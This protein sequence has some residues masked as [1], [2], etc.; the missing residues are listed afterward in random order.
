MRND[1]VLVDGCAVP[2][3]EYGERVKQPNE[4]DLPDQFRFSCS[5]MAASMALPGAPVHAVPVTLPAPFDCPMLLVRTGMHFMRRCLGTARR[6]RL[7][8]GRLA[9]RLHPARSS[10]LGLQRL[11]SEFRRR[12]AGAAPHAGHQLAGARG[13]LANDPDRLADRINAAAERDD[14]RR[15]ALASHG[16]SSGTHDP[17]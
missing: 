2:E 17:A 1:G 4:L 16:H 15:L 9:G 11:V 3:G 6:C 13:D 7:S 10:A 8:R 5:K 14:A 12:D